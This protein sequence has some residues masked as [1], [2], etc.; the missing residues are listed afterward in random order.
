MQNLYDSW[1]MAN[2]LGIRCATYGKDLSACSDADMAQIQKY[3]ADMRILL[4]GAVAHGVAV[5]WRTEW[6]HN[7]I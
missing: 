6:R 2:I 3:G 4:A 7:K 5:R 1:Q